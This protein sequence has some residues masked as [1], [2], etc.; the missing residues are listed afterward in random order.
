MTGAFFLLFCGA[1]VAALA[2]M[3]DAFTGFVLYRT[4]KRADRM[5]RHG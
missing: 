3:A 4:K 2:A 5:R 1:A